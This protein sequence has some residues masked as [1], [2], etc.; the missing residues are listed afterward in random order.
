[1]DR[2]NARLPPVA[3]GVGRSNA[4]HYTALLANSP[5][6]VCSLRISRI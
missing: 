1:M 4:V 5:K 2:V 3:L 6:G